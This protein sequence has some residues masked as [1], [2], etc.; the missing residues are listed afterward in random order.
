MRI[1]KNHLDT[2]QKQFDLDFNLN[3]AI[4]I[5]DHILISPN[6]ILEGARIINKTDP[7]FKLV[8]FFGKVYILAEADTIPGWAEVLK[9]SSAEWFFNFGHLRKIDHILNE[10]DREI[11]DTHI[12]FLPDA[13]A[14]II[15][16]SPDL[17]WFDRKSIDLM[18]DSFSYKNAL[19]YSPTQPDYI[20]V[21][22]PKNNDQPVTREDGSFIEG[23]VKGIAGASIDG[24][25][26]R[27]IGID[28][29]PLSR[30]EGIASTLVTVLKQRII[31]DGFLPFYGTS[32]SHSV[33]RMVAIKSGFLPA[34]S[35]LV[36]GK[37][38]KK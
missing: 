34:Y 7:F 6:K 27:Q 28:V 23:S 2:L 19:C 37:K 24:K 4:E 31:K 22:I 16:E 29:D 38:D 17:V 32:E 36:V 14:E 3:E 20:A 25:Y 11:I 33:S 12:Y 21:A 15:E 26:V 5:N 1:D 8:V 35:E 9:D 10:Y 13:D 30:G 18:K